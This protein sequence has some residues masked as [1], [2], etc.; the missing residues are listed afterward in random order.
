[1]TCV[2]L[3]FLILLIPCVTIA[4]ARHTYLISI[5]GCRRA[6]GSHLGYYRVSREET[7][8]EF[9][10]HSSEACWVQRRPGEHEAYPQAQEPVKPKQ[11]QTCQLASSVPRNSAMGGRLDVSH[12]ARQTPSFRWIVRLLSRFPLHAG[13]FQACTTRQ[14]SRDLILAGLRNAN[15]PSPPPPPVESASSEYV[16][17]PRMRNAVGGI[18]SP[19]SCTCNAAR[20]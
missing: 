8:D 16:P 13:R 14:A 18:L 3:V 6:Q 9:Q 19:G 20:L 15:G 7:D 17:V 5:D 1:M 11:T 10:P 12:Q 4:H 2:E